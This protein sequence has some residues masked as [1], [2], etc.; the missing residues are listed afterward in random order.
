A[1]PVKG[2][3][4]YPETPRPRR[5]H[6]DNYLELTSALRDA[7]ITPSAKAVIRILIYGGFRLGEVLALR[8]TDVDLTGAKIALRDTKTGPRTAYGNPAVMGVISGLPRT[9][10]WVF[11][12]SKD[13]TK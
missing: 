10:E 9:S 6:R 12:S 8:W 4:R 2:I 13:S 1:N 11:P 3:S 5:L 7:R